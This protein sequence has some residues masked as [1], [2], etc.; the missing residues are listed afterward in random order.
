M[1]EHDVVRDVVSESVRHH[2]RTQ[3]YPLEVGDVQKIVEAVRP[4]IEARAIRLVSKT[5]KEFY[6]H[7]G[8]VGDMLDETLVFADE[9]ET[10]YG[11][12]S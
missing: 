4:F 3:K 9:L 12:E 11:N 1:R 5:M 7:G 8:D 2:R 10:R 6:V